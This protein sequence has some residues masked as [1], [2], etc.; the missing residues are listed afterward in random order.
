MLRYNTLIKTNIPS[1]RMRIFF[2]L[3]QKCTIEGQPIFILLYFDS[4]I[5]SVL[6]NDFSKCMT[7]R[8]LE[9]LESKLC[10]PRA[11]EANHDKRSALLI[12]FFSCC[13]FFPH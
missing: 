7:R 9:E 5:L 12:F 8:E 11:R 3:D 4:Y 10:S 1:I 6:H 13:N 2:I